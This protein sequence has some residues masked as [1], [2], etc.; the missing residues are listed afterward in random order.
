[1]IRFLRNFWG[2]EPHGLQ[3]EHECSLELINATV[4]A[5]PE[6]YRIQK[7]HIRQSDKRC[8][9]CGQ[10]KLLSLWTLFRVA[11]VKC[12]PRAQAKPT[13]EPQCLTIPEA[14]EKS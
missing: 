7:E 1:M 2:E 6:C 10:E 11:V 12:Q 4:C 14:W 3:G 9:V 5:N 8:R 13:Q